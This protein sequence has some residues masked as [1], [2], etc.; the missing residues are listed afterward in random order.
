MLA[1]CGYEGQTTASPE[2]VEGTLPQPTETGPA[3]EV[4]EGDAAAG[5][6]VFTANCAACHAKIDAPGFALEAFDPVGGLRSRY[7]SNGKGDQPP[8]KGRTD[9]RVEY[10]LGPVVDASGELRDGRAFRTVSEFVELLA[11]DDEK[12]AR[13]FVAHQVRYATGSEV[14]FADRAE[15]AEI[16]DVEGKRYIDFGGGIGTTLIA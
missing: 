13:A 10:K 5:K 2:T 16:W 3:V 11:A 12:L 14:S 4:P 6:A 8:E 7:R 9:W 1:G 15:N